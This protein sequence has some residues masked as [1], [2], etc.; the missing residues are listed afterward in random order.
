MRAN[1]LPLLQQLAN[2]RNSQVILYVTSDR[3]GLETKIASD[4]LPLFTNHLDTIGD[5]K[6]ISLVLYTQ[7]GET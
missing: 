2:M 7:G 4:V 1:R 5:V 6:K 3:R